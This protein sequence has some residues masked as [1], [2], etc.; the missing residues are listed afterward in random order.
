MQTET[1][2]LSE[3]FDLEKMSPIGRATVVAVSLPILAILM[4]LGASF[5]LLAWI[6]AVIFSYFQESLSFHQ[7]DATGVNDFGGNTG[8]AKG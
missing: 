5:V 1:N 6:P 4:F 2:T 7:A 3:K 8:E